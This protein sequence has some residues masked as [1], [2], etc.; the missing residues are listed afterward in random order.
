M[1]DEMIKKFSSAKNIVFVIIS[2]F[3]F[4][5]LGHNYNIYFAVHSNIS[6]IIVSFAYQDFYKRKGLLYATFSTICSLNV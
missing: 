4:G 2:G 1:C 3:L 6:G 5:L